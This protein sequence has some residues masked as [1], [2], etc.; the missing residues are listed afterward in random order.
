M[1]DV[2][3]TQQGPALRASL[4][5][6]YRDVFENPD[7]LP[8]FLAESCVQRVGPM[9]LSYSETVKHVRHVRACVQKIEYSVADAIAQGDTIADRHIVTL[10]L[11]DGRSAVLEVLCFI[12]IANGKI[13]EL[14]ESSQVL[15]GD[16]ALG[17]LATASE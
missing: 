17:A 16:Q 12:R 4:E 5:R 13:A 6:F 3:K 10:T 2:I 1:F 11:N 14:Y 7:T 9:A 15:S 8:D